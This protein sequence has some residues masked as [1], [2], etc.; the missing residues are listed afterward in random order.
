MTC[1]RKDI[2]GKKKPIL[3]KEKIFTT[4]FLIYHALARR[5]FILISIYAKWQQLCFYGQKINVSNARSFAYL[6]SE[7]HF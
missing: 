5:I 2:S 6:S 7:F 3:G 4:K 1:D